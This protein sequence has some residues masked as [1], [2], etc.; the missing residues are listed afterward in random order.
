[1]KCTCKSDGN[2]AYAG[3]VETVQPLKPVHAEE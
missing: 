2:K 3:V 1:M